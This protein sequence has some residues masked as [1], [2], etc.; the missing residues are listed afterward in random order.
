M[1]QVTD[2]VSTKTAGYAATS[3]TAKLAP[4]SFERRPVGQNDVEIEILYCGVCHSDLHTARNEWKNTMYPCVP[5]HEI[6]GRVK[7]VGDNVKTFKKGDLA[8]VGCL[9]N[10]CRTCNSCKEDLENYCEIG[11]TLTYNSPEKETG[12]TT[13]GGYSTNIVVDQHFV[14]HVSDNLT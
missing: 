8:A 6:V 2:Y 13:F 5:G 4:F 11:F 3:P 9:V 14:L 10:S 1:S 7:K 12:K